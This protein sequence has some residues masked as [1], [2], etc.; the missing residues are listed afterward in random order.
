[1]VSTH[2]RP[3]AAGTMI[4]KGKAGYEV[5][6]HSRPKAAGEEIEQTLAA[7]EVSTHSRPKAAGP[8]SPKPSPSK[9]SFNTQ[10]PEGGWAS[11]DEY[12]RTMPVSTHSRPKA[13]GS[14]PLK[15]RARPLCFNTQPPEGGWC[16]IN[17]PVWRANPFQ[18]TAARRR[19]EIKQQ[20]P[21]PK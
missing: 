12:S 8:T 3:K 13:A 21:K 17:A 15:S 10:P 16:Q 19:L 4:E 9:S 18:H 7:C 11:T 6:T 14:I 5:S 20:Q 1:M 2:S